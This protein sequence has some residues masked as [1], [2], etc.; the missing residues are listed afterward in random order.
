MDFAK[1]TLTN[2]IRLILFAV[3]VSEEALARRLGSLIS[4]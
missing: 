2:L 3:L 1:I 4:P